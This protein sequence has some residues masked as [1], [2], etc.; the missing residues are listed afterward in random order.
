MSCDFMGTVL[1]NKE[2]K[3]TEFIFGPMGL[4]A[5]KELLFITQDRNGN[6]D[7]LWGALSII[8][9]DL[10]DIDEIKYNK[11]VNPAKYITSCYSD[12]TKNIVKQWVMRTK[13]GS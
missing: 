1:V 8:K 10:R 11:L 9:I 7:Y 4:I 2:P 13:E 5:G 3:H 12:E 6:C